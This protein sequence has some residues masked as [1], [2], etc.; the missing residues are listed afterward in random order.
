MAVVNVSG[1]GV[2]TG[3]ATEW[4]LSAASGANVCTYPFSATWNVGPLA[5]SPIAARLK[6]AGIISIAWSY[7]V[8]TAPSCA[9]SNW[10]NNGL[11][12]L[13]QLGNTL[14]IVSFR[15]GASDFATPQGTIVSTLKP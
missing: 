4:S 2:T 7:G 1:P 3:G 8:A 12:G 6:S 9:G 10:D 11:I 13:S 14:T 5:S 15:S